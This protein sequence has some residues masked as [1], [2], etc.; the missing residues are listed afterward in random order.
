[1][2]YY[3]L[4]ASRRSGEALV[5][6]NMPHQWV[7]EY[8]GRPWMYDDPVYVQAQSSVRPFVWR[9]AEAATLTMKQRRYWRRAE[10]FGLGHGATGVVNSRDGHWQVLL[11]LGGSQ[12]SAEKR[13]GV[14]STIMAVIYDLYDVAVASA[15]QDSRTQC[16]LRDSLVAVLQRK[17]AGM[18]T[19]QIAAELH[20][21]ARCIEDRLRRIVESLAVENSAQAITLATH[22]GIIDAKAV[23]SGRQDDKR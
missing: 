8:F 14:L 1:M 15:S 7:D 22:L 11:S 3:A 23:L 17:A 13:E 6:T 10:D 21:S 18:T 12:V 20:K 19:E 2:P 16:V 9:D 4:L 5:C